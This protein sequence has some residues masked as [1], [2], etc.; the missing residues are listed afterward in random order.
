MLC[1]RRGQRGSQLAEALAVGIFILMIT[2]GLIDLIVMV[3]ANSVNDAAARN[4]ARVAANQPDYPK[5]LKAAQDSISGRGK[6]GS[7][8]SSLVLQKVDYTDRRIV[9]CTTRMELKL[10]IPVPG[11]GSNFVFMAKDTEPILSR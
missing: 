8:I 6:P 1:H 9:S 5:A 7:F 3:L 10:P 4:A 2:L 11:I